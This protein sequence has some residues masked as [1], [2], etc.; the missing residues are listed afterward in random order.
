MDTPAL[1]TK[2]VA[3]LTVNDIPFTNQDF[4]TGI[5]EGE[6]DQIL[7]WNEAVLGPV[8]T[9]EQMDAAYAVWEGQQIAAQNKAEAMALLQQT[10]WTATVDISDPTYSIPYLTNQNA[11][12]AYRS[13]VRAIAVNPPTTPVVFP[14][15]PDEE[16]SS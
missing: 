3:Y 9:N 1:S 12:L 15:Q 4:L 7:Y 11:F 10:D 16:W 5:P 8:P 2:L 14:P 6:Q 13:Q